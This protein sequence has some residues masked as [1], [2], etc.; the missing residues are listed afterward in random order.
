M[1]PR[2]DVQMNLRVIAV[3]D[4]CETESRTCCWWNCYCPSFYQFSARDQFGNGVDSEH[5]MRLTRQVYV[6]S[7]GTRSYLSFSSSLTL[8]LEDAG[9]P[10]IPTSPIELFL[11]CKMNCSVMR[12]FI[13][14]IAN[15]RAILRPV[16]RLWLEE[17]KVQSCPPSLST[18]RG[19]Y[20]DKH[21]L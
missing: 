11:R 6:W 21:S 1:L 8:V 2:N 17:E 13:D 14:E 16:P 7:F 19:V 10:L 9:Y 12:A 15:Y 4:Q 3:F 18:V 5:E 20:K